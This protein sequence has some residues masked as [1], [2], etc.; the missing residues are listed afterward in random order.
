MKLIIEYIN[1]FSQYNVKHSNQISNQKLSL[2]KP[3]QLPLLIK[4]G[5]KVTFERNWE[6]SEY[7]FLSL[8]CPCYL[9]VHIYTT[10]NFLFK[11]KTV[12]TL[13]FPAQEFFTGH[14]PNLNISYTN[15]EHSSSF[16]YKSNMFKSRRA[17][18]IRQ[19]QAIFEYIQLER[20]C[21]LLI[22]KW[23]WSRNSFCSKFIKMIK[24][25]I[26]GQFGS[27]LDAEQI[28]VNLYK[29]TSRSCHSWSSTKF[30]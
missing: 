16:D 11:K 18:S 9:M 7:L 8:Q 25:L 30:S 15:H 4:F 14:T 2:H 23:A 12:W 10:W 13:H 24:F 19:D 1:Y 22:L 29:F 21:I 26:L 28:H 5:W 6:Q 17:W 27:L 3:F 20:E